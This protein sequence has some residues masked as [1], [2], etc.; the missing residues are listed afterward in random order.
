[1]PDYRG[2]GIQNA[3]GTVNIGLSDNNPGDIKWDGTAWKGI[4]GNDGT[5]VIFTDTVYGLRAIAVDLTTKINKDGLDTISKIVSA[6]APAADNNNVSAYISA[7]VSDTGIPANQI[8]SADGQTLQLLV[9][10]IVNHEISDSLS[11]QYVSDSDIAQ[12]V[13][14]ASGSATSIPGSLPSPAGSNQMGTAIIVGGAAL[15]AV[16]IFKG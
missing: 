11:D 7:V 12:G 10:A 9:R 13:A 16:L 2:Q 15:L 5:F 1:M 8:L 14:M 3:D 6:Y 4:G